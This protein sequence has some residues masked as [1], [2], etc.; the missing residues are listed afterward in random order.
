[1]ASDSQATGGSRELLALAIP[2]ILSNGFMTMQITLDRLMLSWY[3]AAEVAAAFPAA[4]LFWLPFGLFQGVALY[5]TTFVAQYTGAKRD[6][7]VG[8]AVWTGLYFSL[9]MGLIF[10]VLWPLAPYYVALG[11]HDSK[12]QALETTYLECLTCS[13]LPALITA[14]IS[15]FFSGRGS[16]WAVLGINALGTVVNGVLDYLLI[17]GY[18]GCP[19]M[20]IAG[21]G[22]A[23]VAGAWVSAFAA[24]GLF[25]LPR[26]QATYRT[27]SGWR[28]EW[29]LF[30]RLLKFG[31]PAGLQMALE[32]FAF[33]IFVMLV[34][35]L[36]AAPAAAVSIAITFNLFAFLP[37]YGLGQAVAILVGQRLGED[38]PDLAERSTNLGFFWSMGYMSAI[39]AI[40]VFFPDPLIELFRTN[41]SVA[42][43]DISQVNWAE[44]AAIIPKLLVLIAIYSL[45]DSANIIYSCALRGAGDTK[46][47]TWMSFGLSWPLMVIPSWLIV[48]YGGTVYGAWACASVY[49]IV[50]AVGFWLRFRT[51]KWKSMRVIESIPLDEEPALSPVSER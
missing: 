14:T 40:L 6:H 38:R 44:V 39:A 27:V 12:L 18:Y 43:S 2:L 24:L 16:P 36:G 13:A 11:D 21:A 19:E 49:I 4:M 1:M 9:A 8:P 51:G 42:E 5:V 30:R 22:W 34:G 35:K 7:R 23:T 37:M 50:I 20:G 32:V 41:P 45:A 33:T 17:F 25:F 3:G 26:F 15:G 31:G 48:K 28:P 46:F 47:V 10:L 29:D